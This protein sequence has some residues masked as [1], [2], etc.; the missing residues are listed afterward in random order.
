MHYPN[1]NITSSAEVS[2]TN[3]KSI[4]YFQIT[5]ES[6]VV[7]LKDLKDALDQVGFKL[8]GYQVRLMIDEFGSKQK[9][10]TPGKLNYNEFEQ[11]CIDLKAKEVAS[12]FK[13]VVSK[14]ENLETLGGMSDSSAAGTT[15]SVR[16]EEQ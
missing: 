4:F 3:S 10:K 14:K 15:H 1:L 5:K 11:I 6:G 16:L 7:E 2:T 8:P 13:Q 12:S 9:L